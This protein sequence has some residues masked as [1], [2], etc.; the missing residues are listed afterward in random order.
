MYEQRLYNPVSQDTLAGMVRLIAILI[1][2]VIVAQTAIGGLHGTLVL[3][4]GDHDAGVIGFDSD[5]EPACDHDHGTPMPAPS[6]DHDGECCD[7]V[8]VT[9]AELLTLPRFGDASTDMPMPAAVDAW[10]ILAVD[11]GLSWR[12]PPDPSWV[13]PSREQHLAIVACT[14]LTL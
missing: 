14:R 12:G 9:L 8:Q 11:A 4:L 1:T 6:D 2:L 13:D 5:A 7:D 10:I 3:C